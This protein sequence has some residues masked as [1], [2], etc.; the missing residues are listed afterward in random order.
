MFGYKATETLVFNLY[1]VMA[2][3]DEV[4]VAKLLTSPEKYERDRSRYNIDPERG[5][6][7]SY[8]HL[9]RPQFTVFGKKIEF[10]IQTKDW[11]LRLMSHFK[12]LRRILPGWH[13]KEKAFRDW[14]IE[15]VK[16]FSYFKSQE[17]Y[18]R[19][20]KALN[21]PEQVKGYREIRYPLMEKA[22]KEAIQ[23]LTK[24]TPVT[25]PPAPIP[26]KEQIK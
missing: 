8:V 10:D 16:S 7:V 13:V 14:Y 21:V 25:E 22:K 3:K 12:F 23:H 18:D 2:I 1:R 19:Y 15:L 20:V 11:M 5:D 17:D 24:R 26:I 4:W 6:R 9:N